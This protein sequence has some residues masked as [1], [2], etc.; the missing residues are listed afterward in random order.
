MMGFRKQK[1]HLRTILRGTVLTD[2]TSF[3]TWKDVGRLQRTLDASVSGFYGRE[4]HKVPGGAIPQLFFTVW[5][6][7]PSIMFVTTKVIYSDS[8]TTVYV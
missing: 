2:W 7:Y 6:E 5:D 8:R 1:N 3:S 4:A